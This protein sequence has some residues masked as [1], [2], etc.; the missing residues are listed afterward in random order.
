MIERQYG[1]LIE[2]AQTTSRAAW[3]PF[4]AEQARADEKRSEDS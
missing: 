2:G 3:T 1:T 4:D